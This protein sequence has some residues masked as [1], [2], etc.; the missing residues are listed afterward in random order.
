MAGK[1]KAT[2]PLTW[3]RF[4]G[5][6]GA[7]AYNYDGGAK[8]MVVGSLVAIVGEIGGHWL[9]LLQSGNAEIVEDQ[10]E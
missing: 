3:I 1:K 9:A 2:G 8:T 5:D 7:T 4:T 6:A 10:A